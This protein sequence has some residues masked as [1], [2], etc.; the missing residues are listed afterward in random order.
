MQSATSAATQSRDVASVRWN[1]WFYK[2]YVQGSIHVPA[3][4]RRMRLYAI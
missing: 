2:N 1:L 4:L 3:G